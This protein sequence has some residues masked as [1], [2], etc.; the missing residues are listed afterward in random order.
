MLSFSPD[1]PSRPDGGG[2]NYDDTSTTGFSLTH[3]S[4]PG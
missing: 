1:T 3:M 4:G 2:Y